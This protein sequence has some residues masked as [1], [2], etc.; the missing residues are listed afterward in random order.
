MQAKVGAYNPTLILDRVELDKLHDLTEKALASRI[1]V[2]EST[3]WR[4]S[5]GESAPSAAFIAKVKIAF[6]QANLNRVFAVANKAKA[7][8]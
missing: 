1:G 5:S 3:L 4:V 8:A 6:P 7:A 2:D